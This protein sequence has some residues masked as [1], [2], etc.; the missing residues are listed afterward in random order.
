MAAGA[1]AV[2]TAEDLRLSKKADFQVTESVDPR[3]PARP[4]R[5]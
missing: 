3:W 4:D 2:I 5:D 1:L